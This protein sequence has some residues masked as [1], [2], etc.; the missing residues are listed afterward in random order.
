MACGSVS[1]PGKRETG[2]KNAYRSPQSGD[3]VGIISPAQAVYY[4]GRNAI[5]LLDEANVTGK[6][7]A[8]KLA[9]AGRP[10]L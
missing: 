1:A 7:S 5:S 4:S 10:R 3:P 8:G 6:S 2:N 9:Q